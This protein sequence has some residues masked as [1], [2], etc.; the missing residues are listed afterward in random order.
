MILQYLYWN[1]DIMNTKM[2]NNKNLRWE[3][4]I[5]NVEMSSFQ[6]VISFIETCLSFHKICK[7]DRKEILI[8]VDEI[9]SN[10]CLYSKATECTIVYQGSLD[11]VMICFSDN[12]IAFDVLKKGDPDTSKALGERKIGG[13][14]IYI[15]KSTMD[16]LSYAYHPSLKVTNQL[17]IRKNIGNK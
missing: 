2:K 13:L 1:I 14:G 10:I 12:G 15:V 11:E 3:L 9:Y 8:A 6:K 5:Q 7:E 4:C 17:T 16:S